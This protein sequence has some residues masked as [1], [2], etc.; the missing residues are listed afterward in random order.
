MN[1]KWKVTY[2]AKGDGDCCSVCVR[3]GS[4]K[5]AEYAA[6]REYWDIERILT[7]ERMH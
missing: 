3:A 2:K 5:S 7:I 4:K 6:R 1:K